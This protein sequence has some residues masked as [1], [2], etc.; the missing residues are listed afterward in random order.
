M[1]RVDDTRRRGGTTR[2]GYYFQEDKQNSN[3]SSKRGKTKSEPEE[4]EL[5][6]IKHQGGG[7]EERW[8]GYSQTS[9]ERGSQEEEQISI[10]ST[11]RII[12]ATTTFEVHS[13]DR[14]QSYP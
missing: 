8:G 1:L 11:S 6:T 7:P 3:G 10:H 4:N 14:D 5:D 2:P 13:K 9:V 12:R